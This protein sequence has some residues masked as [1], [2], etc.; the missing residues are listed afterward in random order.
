MFLLTLLERDPL[1]EIF[2]FIFF[3]I[4]CS[5]CCC[6]YS[7]VGNSTCAVR[8]LTILEK[9]KFFYLGGLSLNQYTGV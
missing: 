9:K 6:M 7:I 4:L 3:F 5:Q 8:C 1:F 2:F